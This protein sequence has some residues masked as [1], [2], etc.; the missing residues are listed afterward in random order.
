VKR[1]LL[2]TILV[3]ATAVAA[4][5]AFHATAVERD[6]RMQLNRG[7]AA[8]R[9]D[10][11]Y[12]ALEAY[13][14]AVALRPDSM[15]A[16]LRRA[17]AYTR[18]NEVDEAV[19]D[20]RTAAA[21]DPTATRPLD[22]LGDVMYQRQR[23]RIA[24]ESYESCLRLDERSPRVFYK[25]ALARYREGD[26]DASIAAARQALRLNERMPDAH[27][28]LGLCLRDRHRPAEA[29]Q[30]LEKAVS[31]APGLIAAREE[32]TEIYA[33][34]GRRADE[35]RQLRVL[36]T[37]DRDHAEREVAV[38]LAQMRAGSA[39]LAVLSLGRALDQMPDQAVL[40]AALGRIWL[41]I[42]TTRK[43]HPEALGKA[44]EA[45]GRVASAPSATSD[46]LTIYGR[47]LLQAGDL[48]LAGRT[49]QR[50]T[51]NYPVDPGAFLLYAGVCERLNDFE[52]ARQAL[53]DY[54]ALASDESER[55]AHASRIASLSLRLDDVGVAIDWL[56]KA[57]AAN[58]ADVKV[59]ASLA[60]AQARY[61]DVDAARTTIAR[62]LERDPAN[63]Q[64]MAL[65]RRIR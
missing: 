64:L 55:V 29:V 52:T 32:L 4:A 54:S 15:L 11:T 19:R 38:A 51:T 9:E 58:P 23:Y 20:F 22:E 36:A 37:V 21:L 49:L 34:Q 63:A 43:D 42:A 5:A 24:A 7:D 26:L 25:L 46:V 35:M 61:G 12:A 18:R 60:D 8:L 31:L 39:D 14:G 13:S 30:E 59:L 27:Y 28:L 16:H 44:L 47:A 57:A 17:E 50:A 33:A 65:A 53:I 45:L 1:A 3:I 48:E 56:Q 41:E 2:L 62:G 6:Y 40:Y 10:Q